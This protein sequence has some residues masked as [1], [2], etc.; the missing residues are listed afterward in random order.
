MDA[1]AFNLA[2]NGMTIGTW[3]PRS[4]KDTSDYKYFCLAMCILGNEKYYYE[5]TRAN[6]P[7]DKD[8]VKKIVSYYRKK[9][10]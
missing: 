1:W 6:Y 2:N 8:E 7:R 9:L 5:G 3:N 4:S 10:S